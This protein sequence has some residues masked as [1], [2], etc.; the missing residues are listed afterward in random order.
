MKSFVL[1][2]FDIA[3]GLEL[4]GDIARTENRLRLHYDLF[5]EFSEVVIPAAHSPQRR[6]NLWQTTCFE[7][8]LG[9][10]N[11]P[12]YWEFNLSPS[13]DWNVYRFESYRTG[14]QEEL[15]LTQLPFEFDAIE[16]SCTID[17]DLSPIIQADQ[18]LN[19]S[20]TA[21]IQTLDEQITYWAIQHCGAEAD[22]HLRESFVLDI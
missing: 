20:I 15:T 16:K 2:P 5:D 3:L 7:F 10:Q 1:A 8:F 11:S 4:T 18:L 6:N 19:V 17:F 21:V 13:G 22:F 9:V 12:Q 14:M